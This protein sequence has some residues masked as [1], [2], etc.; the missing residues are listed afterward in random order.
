MDP[1]RKGRG[2]GSV[3]DWA[4][5]EVDYAFWRRGRGFRDG[6]KRFESADN[7]Y[8]RPFITSSTGLLIEYHETVWSPVRWMKGCS[9]K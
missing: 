9:K 1:R 7:T 4:E 6:H 2:D 3:V 5:D 8:T